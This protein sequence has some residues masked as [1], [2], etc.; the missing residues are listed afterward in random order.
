MHLS[1]IHCPSCESTHITTRDIA[2]HTG[3]AVGLVGGA[4]QGVSGAMAG[5]RLGG[6]VGVIA[7]PPGMALGSIAGAILGGL[8]GGAAG[9]ITGAKIGQVVDERLLN[10]YRCLV[11][12]HCF[13]QDDSD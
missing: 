8:V 12:D 3:G 1:N 11:C 6:A 4:L 5:A 9:G 13:S 10:N 7:G 2:K